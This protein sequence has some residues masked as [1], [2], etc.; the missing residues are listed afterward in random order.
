MHSPHSKQ[1]LKPVHKIFGRM[2]TSAL[3][4]ALHVFMITNPAHA[5]R[6]DFQYSK[7]DNHHFCAMTGAVDEAD[8][9]M[10]KNNISKGCKS[11]L[12]N[13]QG[14]SVIAAIKMGRLL[15]KNQMDIQVWSGGSCAS[16]CIFLYAGAVARIP[17]GSVEIHRLYLNNSAD[18]YEETA[19]KYVEIESQVKKFL[20]E[21]NIKEIL[22]DDMMNI[23]PENTKK[24]TLEELSNY[25]LGPLDPIHSE[26]QAN[27]R[28]KSMG[29]SKR[30]FLI[31]KARAS[32]VCGSLDGYIENVDYSCWDREFPGFLKR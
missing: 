9:D 12:V 19:S 3:L 20:R 6:H 5:A 28:A 13:S 29:I 27:Q 32:S 26:F 17:Y 30:E 11:L 31:R 2:K 24:L 8:V 1:P 25:G 16:A 4:L 7:S 21:M 14:G 10:L 22:Y 15:R 18:S 23:P